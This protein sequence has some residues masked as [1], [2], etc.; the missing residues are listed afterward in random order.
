MRRILEGAGL[1]LAR[2]LPAWRGQPEVREIAALTLEAIARARSLIYL[3]NQ[4]F[5]RPLAVEALAARLAEPDGPEI[6]LICT[7]RSPS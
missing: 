1:G 2:T 4:Y 7:G 3:E 5:T 6:V